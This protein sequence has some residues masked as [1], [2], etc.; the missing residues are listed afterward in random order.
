M[1]RSA[2]LKTVALLGAALLLD[3]CGKDAAPTKSI[4]VFAAASLSDA[5]T[6][7]AQVYT[8]ETGR[9]VVLNF[10]GSGSLAKQIM[11]S[12]QADVYLSANTRWMDEV[13]NAGLIVDGSRADLLSNQ[14]VVVCMQSATFQLSKP[15]E[16]ASLDFQYL[17]IGDPAYVPAGQYA[18]GWLEKLSAL[19]GASVWSHLDG[20]LSPMPDVR[21]ALKQ[22]SNN[23]KLVG[24]VY[25]TDYLTEKDQLRE[26]YA[27]PLG[28]AA[29]IRYC[30]AE[31]AGADE[32][33]GAEFL[34]FLSTPAVKSVFERYGFLPVTND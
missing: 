33:S 17:V 32:T 20:R 24:I 14:L 12:P 34:K 22:V 8:V 15:A 18:K 23:G 2:T 5:V 1:K 3:A 16:L 4:T 27:V 13:E 28:A 10:A 7:I 6:E 31:I 9:E 25:R 30:V 26:L 11:A 21:A 29:P 19:D